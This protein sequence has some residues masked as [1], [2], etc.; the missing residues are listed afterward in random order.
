MKIRT[1]LIVSLAVFIASNSFAATDLLIKE[2][3]QFGKTIRTKMPPQLMIDTLQKEFQAAS[4]KWQTFWQTFVVEDDPSKDEFV[5][6]ARSVEKKWAFSLEKKD[7]PKP[8]NY[9][10]LIQEI[11]TGGTPVRMDVLVGI[12][13]QKSWFRYNVNVYEPMYEQW[14]NPCVLWSLPPGGLA[15]DKFY[16]DNYTTK[17]YA[18]NLKNNVYDLVKVFADWK[19]PRNLKKIPAIRGSGQ[20]LIGGGSEDLLT[21]EEKKLPIKKQEKLLKKRIKERDKEL[22]KLES[23]K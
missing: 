1:E 11:N 7:C 6:I 9:D 21:D 4:P 17:V 15:K 5:I 8:E 23:K 22:K 20:E 14:K 12:K 10:Q 3:K 13:R 18:E 19:P 2:R 16:K